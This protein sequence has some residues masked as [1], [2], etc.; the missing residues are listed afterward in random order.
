MNNKIHPE[1][2]EQ[3]A[4]LMKGVLRR[5]L[6]VLAI[7]LFYGAIRF[8]SAGLLDWPVAWIYLG[9]YAGTVLI[10]TTLLLPRNPEFIAERGK[11]K[12]DIK[13]WD[14]TV[15][16]L[17]GIFMISGLIVP[18]LDLRFGWSSPLAIPLYVVGFCVFAAGCALFS[19]AMISNEFFETK[20]R[21]QK[22]RGQMV[23]TTG[24]YR[25]VRHP[26]YVGMI[27]QLIATPFALGSLWGVIPA[28]CAA[29]T[30]VLRTALEDKTLRKEL[31]GYRDYVERVRYR[32]L[33]GVW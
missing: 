28:L 21:I 6:Q 10:N 18:G 23:A 8:I 32:L 12:Q 17:A 3:K 30:F 20:V 22:D 16:N 14:K 11:E 2:Y 25:Y 26:G 19:W 9:I 15:T 5:G 27:L 29:G 31:D 7:F 24:P 4:N 1:S 13:G 33:P